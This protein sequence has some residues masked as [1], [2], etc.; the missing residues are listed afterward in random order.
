MRVVGFP[1]RQE[2]CPTW[3]QRKSTVIWPTDSSLLLKG[4]ASDPK[5]GTTG[6]TERQRNIYGQDPN[7]GGTPAQPE[8]LIRSRKQFKKGHQEDK[9]IEYFSYAGSLAVWEEFLSILRIP[10]YSEVKIVSIPGMHWRG[11]WQFSNGAW[12]IVSSGSHNEKGAGVLIMVHNSLCKAKDLRFNQLLS[13]RLLH[14]WQGHRHGCLFV[15]PIR[16]TIQGDHCLQQGQ[17]VRNTCD[18]KELAQP[19]PRRNGILTCP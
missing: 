13:G 19:H 6:S 7:L 10:S 18:P 2:L 3:A 17:A 5:S 9:G 15:L 11:S 12:H 1:S 4:K 14:S 16:L 8:Q